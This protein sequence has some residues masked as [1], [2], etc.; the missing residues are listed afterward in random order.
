M[1]AKRNLEDPGEPFRTAR[2]SR[3]VEEREIAKARSR[4]AGWIL[5]HSPKLLVFR[6]V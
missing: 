3:Q 2:E 4:E 5:K 1:T 6:T